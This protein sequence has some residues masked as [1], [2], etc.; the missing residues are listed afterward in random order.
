MPAVV[1]NALAIEPGRIP[2]L[3]RQQVRMDVTAVALIGTVGVASRVS[4]PL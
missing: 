1:P 2:G 4:T 3:V